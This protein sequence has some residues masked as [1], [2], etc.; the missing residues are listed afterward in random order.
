VVVGVVVVIVVALFGVGQI[1]LNEYAL[2]PGRATPV[3]P[4]VSVHGVAT[5]RHPGRILLT[6]VYL[7]AL[8]VGSWVSMHLSSHVQFVPAAELTQPGE[9]TSEL[10][11]QGYLQMRDA[12][13]AAEVE[14]F[15]TLGW[16]VTGRSDGATIGGV[17][18]PSPASRAGLGVGDVVTAV[19]ARPVRDACALIAA[20]HPLAPGT[21]VALSVR[22]VHISASGVLTWRGTRRVEV[23]TVAPPTNDAASGCPGVAGRDHSF[24]GVSLEDD[25][26]YDLPAEVRINTAN[27]G[28]PSAGLAMTLTLIDLLSRDS[29]SGPHDVAATGTMSVGGAVGAVGGVAQK[30]VAVQSAG[31]KYFIVPR[32]EVGAARS[33]APGLTVCGVTT[34]AGAMRCLRSLGGGAP[35][36]L[37]RPP[38]RSG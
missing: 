27:I 34:L 10:T 12:Q 38:A 24:V 5:A 6:D 16:T 11:A 8:T 13:Q 2:T 29:I 32:S 30:A 7:Q 19:N 25:V 33:G 17:V 36:P 4:L 35:T 14:A 9:P 23:T 31:A 28:G 37:T 15:R 1:P 21:R 20:I 18:Q 26:A 22:L 3:A